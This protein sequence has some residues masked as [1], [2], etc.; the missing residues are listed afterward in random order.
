MRGKAVEVKPEEGAQHEES[1][2]ESEKEEQN[3]V[4]AKR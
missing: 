1:R 4:G 3:S 2:Q